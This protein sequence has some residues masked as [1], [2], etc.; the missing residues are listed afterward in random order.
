MKEQ[1]KNTNDYKR[2]FLVSEQQ[3]EEINEI[4]S[5]QKRILDIL[6]KAKLPSQPEGTIANKFVPEAKAKEL[7]GK[8][9]TWFYNQRKAGKLAARKMGGTNYYLLSDIE[10]LF[11]NSNC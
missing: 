7:L 9:T 8:G 4:K 5:D 6:E 11:E 10:N 2:Y 3:I 1:D